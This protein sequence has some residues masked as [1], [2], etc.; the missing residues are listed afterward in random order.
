ML[1]GEAR[2]WLGRKEGSRSRQPESLETPDAWQSINASPQTSKSGIGEAVRRGWLQAM[3]QQLPIHW[4]DNL[5]RPP[6]GDPEL[7]ADIRYLLSRLPAVDMKNVPTNAN[8]A[9]AGGANSGDRKRPLTSVGVHTGSDAQSS[10][11]LLINT[12]PWPERVTLQLQAPRSE[13]VSVHWLPPFLPAPAST[14]P[15][16]EKT[17]PA[18]QSWVRSAS[19]RLT[20]ETSDTPPPQ[21]LPLLNPLPEQLRGEETWEL[22]LP[23][24]GI[25]LAHIGRTSFKAHRSRKCH[26]SFWKKSFRHC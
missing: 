19:Y 14:T 11:L 5:N 2:P 7:T 12:A 17:N 9:A 20:R 6:G 16:T 10:Y 23:A 25:R 4:L 24:F 26:R 3:N 1:A 21:P 18:W 15:P 22:T 13:P 8:S